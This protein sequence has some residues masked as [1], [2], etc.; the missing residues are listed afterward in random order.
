MKTTALILFVCTLP[1]VGQRIL[2]TH[3]L[4]PNQVAQQLRAAGDTN[5]DGIQ[6]F[7]ARI[8][9]FNEQTQVNTWRVQ[10]GSGSSGA[11]L[12]T[13]PLGQVV[14]AADAVGIGDVNGDG[15]SD[16][17]VVT[18]ILLR[19]FS[20]G[21]GALIYTAP[22]PSGENYVAVCEA[23]DFDGDGIADLVGLTVN[24]NSQMTARVLRGTNGTQLT[25][26]QPQSSGGFAQWQ[27]RS[28][29][30]VTGDGKADVVVAGSGTVATALRTDTGTV[31]WATAAASNEFERRIE[32]VDLDGDQRRELIWLR[33]SQVQP[34]GTSGSAAVYGSNGALRYVVTGRFGLESGW[35]GAVSGLGDLDLDGVQDFALGIRDGAGGL[36]ACSGRNGAFLWKFQGDPLQNFGTALAAIADVDGDGFTDFAAATDRRS[37]S[38]ATQWHI[39]SGKIVADAQPQLG[40]CGGSSFFPRLG[41]S[42]PIVGQNMTIT[43]LDGPANTGGVLV[44]SLRP[45]YPAYLGVSSCFAWFDLGAGSALAP[46]TQPQWNLVLPV[47]AVPQLAGLEIALQSYYAPTAGPLGLDL[48]NGVWA[49][50]GYP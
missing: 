9:D 20:G 2:Q 23:G 8:A 27:V 38:A 12:Q 43:G 6:D 46:L 44:F 49:R 40:A 25:A 17:A 41:A 15:R 7:V 24:S 11:V 39:V 48:S 19:V 37:P 18:G 36:I 29:G 3:T 45:P 28:L 42:R 22:L 13:L 33:P 35:N 5:G 16:I 47:P 4:G 14:N 32:T 26:C 1:L 10:I 31:L 34:N 21:S 30:D 50:I